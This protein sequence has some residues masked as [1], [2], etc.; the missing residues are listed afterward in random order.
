MARFEIDA[1]NSLF[2]EYTRGTAQSPVTF[3][4]FNALTG[5]ANMWND[6]VSQA[7]LGAG[8]G[9]LLYNMR[10]Q[11]DSPFSSGIKLDQKLIVDDAVQLLKHVQPPNPVFVGL[12]IGGIFAAWSAHQGAECAG[13]VF[14]NTLR[15]DGP[16]LQ[17]I[18]DSVVRLAE[19]GGGDLLRDIMSPLL[20]NEDWQR[21]N[22]NNCLAQQNYEPLDKSSGTYN[23]LSSARS[24]DWDFPYEQLDMPTM[25]I[26]GNHDRVFRD[27]ADIENM[28]ARLPNARRLDMPDAGHMIPVEQ[29]AAL[30]DAL[31]DMANWVGE[32][33]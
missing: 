18:N 2:Y 20:M 25:V 16:R 7:L 6:S 14:L 12:S 17:W 30:A 22:R 9:I 21:D 8:H 19:L 1:N 4:F 29:P 28:Y 24:T 32:S 10:G 26:T 33:V 31:L 23:L 5:D 3:V 13:M 11:R 27:P 15:R